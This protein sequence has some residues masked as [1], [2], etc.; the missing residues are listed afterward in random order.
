MA[1]LTLNEQVARLVSENQ[2]LRAKSHH[3]DST[4]GIISK[5]YADLVEIIKRERVEADNE[6]DELRIERDQ[7]IQA[8]R[9]MEV[10]LVQAS[11]FIVQAVRARDGHPVELEA[12]E[13]VEYQE[14]EKPALRAPPV[15]DE[16]V[17]YGRP[18][19][20][21]APRVAQQ[22]TRPPADPQWTGGNTS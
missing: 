19:L 17:Q 12:E 2:R 4:I 7:A 21:E 20:R 6:I 10:I 8:Y 11:D 3:D 5:Q 13:P 14:A 16:A 22:P 1:I 15:Q 9:S 18:V